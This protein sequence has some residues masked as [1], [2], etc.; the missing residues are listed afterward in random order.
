[1]RKKTVA[2]AQRQVPM[3][4]T[5]QKAAEVPR[6]ESETLTVQWTFQKV[7]VTVKVPQAEVIVEIIQVPAGDATP[8]SSA[9]DCERMLSFTGH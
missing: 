7:H 4:Q 5:A 2:E 9:A 3:L 8:G 1:M 6:L